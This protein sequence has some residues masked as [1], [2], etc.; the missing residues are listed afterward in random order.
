VKLSKV[1]FEKA[2]E[3]IKNRARPLD[4]RLFEF[5]FDSGSAGAVLSE[6]AA[7]QNPDGGFGHGIEPDFRSPASSPMATSVGLQYSVAVNAGA[8]HPIV[9]YAIRYLLGTYDTAADYWPANFKAVN[10]APH[11]PWWHV[12]EIK[13]PDEADWPNPSAELAGYLRRYASLVPYDSLERVTRRARCNLEHS[14]TFGG[15]F[16]YNLLCWQ[17]AAAN[18]PADFRNAVNTR[19]RATFEKH[20]FNRENYGEVGV[21]WLAPTPETVLARHDPN[22]VN[23]QLDVT[24]TQ[25][26]EDGGWWPAWQW[27]QNEKTWEIAKQEWAGKMTVETLCTLRSYDRIEDIQPGAGALRA[28]R[29]SEHRWAAI[30]QA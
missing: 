23:A 30:R 4:V 27:G 21:I 29:A 14:E 7:Y 13:P 1:K 5:F 22:A 19:I 10:D 18:L 12:E 8:G 25:Q 2:Q 11:A 6:L 28:Q 3:F 17:R 24:L 16:R 20:P 9:Q 15:L 26:A